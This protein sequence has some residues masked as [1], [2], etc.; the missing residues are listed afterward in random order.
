MISDILSRT[1]TDLDHYLNDVNFDRT[2][3]G[4]ARE[5]LIRLRDEADNRCVL[6]LPPDAIPTSDAG[7]HQTSKRCF[8][9][10]YDGYRDRF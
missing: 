8:E 9:R 10:P 2:Y 1:V 3:G 7:P 4:E 5:G 6:D